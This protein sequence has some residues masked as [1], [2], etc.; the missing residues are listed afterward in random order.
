MRKPGKY[1]DKFFV[2]LN[3]GYIDWLYYNPDSTLGGQYV[4]NRFTQDHFEEALV[5]YPKGPIEKI[6]GY[7]EENCTQYLADVGTEFYRHCMN[8]F[9]HEFIATG[10]SHDT[11]DYINYLFLAAEV[12]NMYCQKEFESKADFSNI[13]KV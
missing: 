10:I 12:I 3:G 4:L 6:F 2:D 11:F 9:E 1:E 13:E 7:V 5:L 8:R